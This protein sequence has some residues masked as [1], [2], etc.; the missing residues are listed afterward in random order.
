MSKEKIKYA[1]SE[2]TK[3]EFLK[4]ISDGIYNAFDQRR[5]NG[6]SVIPSMIYEG[7]KDAFI[8]MIKENIIKIPNGKKE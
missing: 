3:E 1:I 2:I 6:T 8:Q 5:S 4:A 7:C